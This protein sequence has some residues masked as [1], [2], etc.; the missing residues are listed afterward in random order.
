AYVLAIQ[1]AKKTIHMTCAYFVPD[2]QILQAL[3]DAAHRGVDVK[4]IL[5]GVT[6]SGLLFH[7][8]QSFYSEMLANGIKIYQLQIAVL[9]AKTAVIDK[10][11]S[12]VGSTNIDTR[13]FLHNNEINVVVFGDEFG[14]AMENAFFEDLRSSVEISKET[15]EQRSLGNRLKEWIARRFEYWL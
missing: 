4:I 6:D 8:A 9:H 2:A 15:W 1:E 5:P 14:T 13:S 7:A 3:I 10:V 12:T 11:W